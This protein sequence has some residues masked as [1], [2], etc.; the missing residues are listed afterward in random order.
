MDLEKQIEVLAEGQ[1][2]LLDIIAKQQE[3]IN[4]LSGDSGKSE[5][6][7]L[8]TELKD[9]EVSPNMKAYLA[10]KKAAAEAREKNQNPW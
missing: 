10:D 1:Q 4:K 5:D 6:T 7:L 9:D 2:K 8:D 3:S